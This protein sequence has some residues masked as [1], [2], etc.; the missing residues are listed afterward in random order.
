MVEQP[1]NLVTGF[2]ATGVWPLTKDP[3]SEKVKK[4]G[5]EKI[6]APNEMTTSNYDITNLVEKLFPILF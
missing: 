2:R 5:I 4:R 3:I 1:E 6:V